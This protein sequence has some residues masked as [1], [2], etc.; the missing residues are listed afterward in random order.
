MHHELSTISSFGKEIFL[1]C[2]FVPFGAKSLLVMSLDI[3]KRKQFEKALTKSNDILKGVIESPK[4]VVIFALDHQYRYIAF[5]K[6]HI[7][8]LSIKGV[9]GRYDT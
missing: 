2:Y 7:Y 6:N 1:D 4:G 5:N 8:P 3:T 9:Y